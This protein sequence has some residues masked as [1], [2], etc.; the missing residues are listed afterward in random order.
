VKRTLESITDFPRHARFDYDDTTD[1][2]IVSVTLHSD[3]GRTAYGE[4][5]IVPLHECDDDLLRT[6]I[7]ELDDIVADEVSDDAT[8]YDLR[9][10]LRSL[11]M[12]VDEA[13]AIED[14][15]K[16]A[17]LKVAADLRAAAFGILDIWERA[18][19]SPHT[20]TASRVIHTLLNIPH[21]PDAQQLANEWSAD[22][23]MRHGGAIPGAVL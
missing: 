4:D 17:Q 1:G 19:P 9:V 15:K 18:K 12:T 22:W 3:G 7:A 10:A 2:L 11:Y 13:T 14:A 5:T 20:M 21:H 8:D 16:A 6:A 23:S